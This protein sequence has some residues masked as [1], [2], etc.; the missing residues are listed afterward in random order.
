MSLRGWYLA[1]SGGVLFAVVEA[2]RSNPLFFLVR[3]SFR[4]PHQRADRKRLAGTLPF[5]MMQTIRERRIDLIDNVKERPMRVLP[6]QVGEAG[7]VQVG[8][9]DDGGLKCG[10]GIVLFM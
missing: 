2:G 3:C 6:A 1:L 7:G 10:H 4:Q 8:E 5:N 9:A